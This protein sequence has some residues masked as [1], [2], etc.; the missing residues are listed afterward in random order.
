[1]RGEGG[2]E[3]KR[4]GRTGGERKLGADD[5]YMYLLCMYLPTYYMYVAV[6]S[7]PSGATATR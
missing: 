7:Q 4:E 2:R 3:S 1:M 5:T 6:A